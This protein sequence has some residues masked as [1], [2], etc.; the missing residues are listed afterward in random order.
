MVFDSKRYYH[1]ALAQIASN[2]VLAVLV[3]LVAFYLEYYNPKRT[4]TNMLIHALLF[5]GCC[6]MHNYNHHHS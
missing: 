1:A 5:N 4:R 6:G 2:V 3:P